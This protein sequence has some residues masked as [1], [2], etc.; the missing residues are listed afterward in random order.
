MLKFTRLVRHAQM[1]NTSIESPGAANFATLTANLAQGYQTIVPV[2]NQ[3]GTSILLGIS[4]STLLSLQA[5]QN[6]TFGIQQQ[7]HVLNDR[8]AK[9]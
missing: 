1:G 6:S 3:G 2:A 9:Q 8:V 5:A 7:F 4:A